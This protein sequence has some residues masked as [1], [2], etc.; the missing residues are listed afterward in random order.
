MRRIARWCV[1]HRLV[2]IAAWI[3]VLVGTVFISSSTGSNYSSGYKLSGTQSAIAQNLLHKASPG[4]AGDSEQI[5][6]ATHGGSVTAPA[7]RAQIQPMLAKV[8]HLPNVASVTS[9]YSRS[10]QIISTRPPGPGWI[11]S[12]KPCNFAIATTRLRPRP[13]PGVFR[14]LSER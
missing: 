5:V 4:A 3:V 1:N 14:I 11:A 13:T 10:G 6:F 7:V 12:R 8:A 2:V 9:P